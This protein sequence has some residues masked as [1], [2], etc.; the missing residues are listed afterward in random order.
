M[1]KIMGD[2]PLMDPLKE[3]VSCMGEIMEEVANYRNYKNAIGYSFRFFTTG[4]NPNNDIK[5]ISIN[6][7]KPSA[8]NISNGKY[9][10]VVNLYA[11]TVQGNPKSSV[12]PFLKWMQ[13]SQG[14]ELVE[15]VG[16]IPLK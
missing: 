5:L 2:T 16:Y 13:G 14:Q 10:Y 7:I 6:G 9:P 12:A 15:D 8:E 11:I 4:M 1:E 3:E